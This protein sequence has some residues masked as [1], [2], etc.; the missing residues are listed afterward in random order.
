MKI[1]TLTIFTLTTL[2]LTACAPAEKI[3]ADFNQSVDNI[4]KEATAV[5]EKLIKTKENIETTVK[6][7][8]NLVDAV[9]AF[10]EEKSETQIID[11]K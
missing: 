11:K 2:V 5:K 8:E 9:K 1:L 4:K 10:G 6:K 3:K 7:V